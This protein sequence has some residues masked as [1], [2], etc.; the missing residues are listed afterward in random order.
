[1]GAE[2]GG[3]GWEQLGSRSGNGATLASGECRLKN[4]VAMVR[5]QER[6]KCF[7]CSGSLCGGRGCN[8]GGKLMEAHFSLLPNFVCMMGFLWLFGTPKL[9]SKA[10]CLFLGFRL[11][12]SGCCQQ[13]QRNTP[14]IRNGLL[15]GPEYDV[16]PLRQSS[17]CG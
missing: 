16:A 6:K 2:G 8:F 11:P 1:L 7:S 4:R 12:R 14:L 3:E 10:L 15:R 13:A 9:V 5:D 17:H